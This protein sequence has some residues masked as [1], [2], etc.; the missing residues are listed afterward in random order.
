MVFYVSKSINGRNKHNMAK[1]GE[2]Q[3]KEKAVFS[4]KRLLYG[5]A[6][7]I[8]GALFDAMG[9]YTF[10]KNANFAPGGVSGLSLI[11][12]HV[13]NL[14]LGLLTIILN[15]PLVLFSMRIIGKKFLWKT[16]RSMVVLTL[17]LDFIF[18]HLPTYTGDPLLAALFSGALIGIGLSIFYLQGS[19]TGGTDFI[20]MSVKKLRPHFSI[21]K[22]MFLTDLI[23]IMI[24][25]P[26][27]GN[28][29]AVLYGLASTVITSI[30]IDRVMY[31][32]DRG[33]LVIIVTQHGQTVAD[34]I[35]DFTARG[36][37]KIHAVGTYT[38]QE[39]DVL[40]CACSNSQA[41]L[42]RRAAYETDP[43][44]F[45]MMTETGSVF[46][47]GFLAANDQ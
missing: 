28:V 24:G 4:W 22:V 40:L 36:S 29:D 27:F 44:A 19:S 1:H 3:P 39:K 31:G 23:I 25:W 45:V 14:P 47:K 11:I 38:K 10:A 15:I 41:Y 18:P 12:N 16:L 21:G 30:V 33:T 32:A 6:L 20:I 26:V 9:L 2:L 42:V 7:D 13:T 5:L 46:G 37:T 34:R 8:V 43:E 17:F 35:S